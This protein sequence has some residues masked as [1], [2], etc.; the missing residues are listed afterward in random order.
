MDMQLSHSHWRETRQTPDVCHR[1]RLSDHIPDYCWTSL[2][3]T[4]SHQTLVMYKFTAVSIAW[5]ELVVLCGVFLGNRCHSRAECTTDG[6]ARV[7]DRMDGA[8]KTARS[9]DFLCL[10]FILPITLDLF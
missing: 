9:L 1:S 8:L 7:F 10:R 3:L 4:R 2:L 6:T 5:S